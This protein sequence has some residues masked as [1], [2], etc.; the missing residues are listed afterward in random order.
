M[1]VNGFIILR[2]GNQRIPPYFRSLTGPYLFRSEAEGYASV[3][4]AATNE[5]CSLS[6]I[7]I[8]RI[9]SEP[10]R[11]NGNWFVTNVWNIRSVSGGF[12]GEVIIKGAL[13][14]VLRN[15][16]D[17]PWQVIEKVASPSSLQPES[18]GIPC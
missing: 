3:I 10:V 8:E 16:P 7:A 13:Y 12:E 4:T 5:H 6:Q 14:S 18:P 1:P 9:L 11:F 2:D 17:K 15:E